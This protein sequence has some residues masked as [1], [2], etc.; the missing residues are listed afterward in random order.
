M[1]IELL[2][3]ISA[4]AASTQDAKACNAFIHV[5]TNYKVAQTYAPCL[6]A[7]E[8]GVGP[9]EYSVG[10]GYGFA[11]QPKLEELYYRRAA[12]HGVSAAYLGIL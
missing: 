4:F 10:M 8:S 3:T 11:G 12:E 6:K 1:F 9:A 2:F 5:G 7:A